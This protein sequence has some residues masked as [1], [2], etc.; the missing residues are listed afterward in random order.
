MA[1]LAIS[2]R[3]ARDIE[4]IKRFSCEQW[5][6]RVAD[7]YLDGFEDALCRLRD[8]PGLL[9][10]KP[11]FSPHFRFCRVRRHYLVCALIEENVYVLAVKHGSLDLPNR[12]AELE[13]GL[14]E[15]ANMLH[16][17]FLAQKKSPR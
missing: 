4:E 7:E 13:P 9:R 12:L 8:N 11:E 17:A 3:A 1:Y 15:E 5:G 10:G 16:R 6:H 2:R 14:I